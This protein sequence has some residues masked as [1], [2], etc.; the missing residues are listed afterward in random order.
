MKKIYVHANYSVLNNNANLLNMIGDVS[1]IDFLK[2]MRNLYEAC[3]PEGI[4]LEAGNLDLVRQCDAVLFIDAPNDSALLDFVKTSGV[5]M[6]LYVW[7]SP[8]VNKFNHDVH[9]LAQFKKVFTYNTSVVPK[10]VDLVEVGYVLNID[11]FRFTKPQELICCITGNRYSQ[12]EGELYS[13]RRSLIRYLESSA[14]TFDLY[15][16][17]WNRFV[18]PKN[19][20]QKIY[21]KWL[22]DY[23]PYR[24]YPS[25]KGV[26]DVKEDI[27]CRYR[28]SI[29]FE[30]TRNNVG[31][32]SEKI[33]SCI[34]SG[35]MPIYLGCLNL[36]DYISP[37]LYVDY[38]EFSSPS[39]LIEF[40]G[41]DQSFLL[42]RYY[43]AREKF[44]S[45]DLGVF[46]QEYFNNVFITAFKEC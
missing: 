29:C 40:L 28:F 3:L 14:L 5:P 30:N 12:E 43:L 18:P 23:F 11:S 10:G 16:Q 38:S 1:V 21:N 26:V 31:Y 33:L 44:L 39:E 4:Y 15:G 34:A 13:L 45:S 41:A 22:C 20:L 36:P 19:I 42:E 8:L 17:G 2:M 35:S 25:W 27:L 9:Y 6:F 46:G 37:D 7:E 32:V 24:P